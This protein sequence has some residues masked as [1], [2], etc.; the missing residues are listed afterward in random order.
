[1]CIILQHVAYHQAKFKGN[2][3]VK[4]E[5]GNPISICQQLSL[6]CMWIVLQAVTLH[7]PRFSTV[8][9]NANSSLSTPTPSLDLR[10]VYEAPFPSVYTPVEG[11]DP[12][13][14]SKEL[15]LGVAVGR[16]ITAPCS[17]LCQPMHWNRYF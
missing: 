10:R 6:S 8:E 11:T 4:L 17:R 1:M 13:T 12:G 5:A 9:R 3:I 15:P 7:Q 2:V 16:P 14:A